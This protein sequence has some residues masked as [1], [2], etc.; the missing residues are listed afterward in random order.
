MGFDLKPFLDAIPSVTSAYSLIAF[1]LVLLSF[2]IFISLRSNARIYTILEKKFT[3]IQAYSFLN[4][5]A[6]YIF[7]FACLV[8]ILGYISEFGNIYKIKTAQTSIIIFDKSIDVSLSDSIKNPQTPGYLVASDP[9]FSIPAP[10]LEIWEEPLWVTDKLELQKYFNL[11]LPKEID[12][13]GPFFDFISTGKFLFLLS[14]QEIDLE[15][16]Q[17]SSFEMDTP[18]EVNSLDGYPFTAP[19]RIKGRHHIS[20]I[21]IPKSNLQAKFKYANITSIATYYISDFYIK[22]DQLISTKNNAMITTIY[23]FKKAIFQGS[24]QDVSVFKCMRFIDSGSHFFIIEGACYAPDSNPV[25]RSYML[26]VVSKF[27][28]PNAA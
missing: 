22:P 11:S 1:V 7:L 12:F 3:K 23:K 13:K 26:N 28:L 24:T 16:N 21:S 17:K 2:S 6:L 18:F 25:I 4:R 8:F 14:K 10:N 20:I 9:A 15:I 27:G 5:I 19:I